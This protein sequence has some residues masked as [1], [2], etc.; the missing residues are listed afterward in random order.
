MSQTSD[1]IYIQLRGGRTLPEDDD[2]HSVSPIL[3]PLHHI[4]LV[5]GD[6]LEIETRVDLNKPR[7]AEFGVVSLTSTGLICYNKK[8]YSD[9]TIINQSNLRI[10]TGM[11]TVQQ[12]NF[13]LTRLRNRVK[14]VETNTQRPASADVN[15]ISTEC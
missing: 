13:S 3:G 12:F 7:P 15:L 1:G 5:H 4:N 14:Q 6:T 2:D 10:S 11:E 8:Y 9:V